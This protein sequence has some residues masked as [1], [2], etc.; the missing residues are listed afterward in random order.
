MGGAACA[1]PSHPLGAERVGRV[2]VFSKSS[3]VGTL[4]LQCGSA[5]RMMMWD[6]LRHGV[7]EAFVGVVMVSPGSSPSYKSGLVI[8][9]RSP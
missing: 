3:H 4:V 2:G 6:T 8:E 9:S 7:G 1:F 5:R